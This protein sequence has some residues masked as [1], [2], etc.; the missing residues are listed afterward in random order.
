MVIAAEKQRLMLLLTTV[1][2]LLQWQLGWLIAPLWLLW[3]LLLY[4]HRD[5]RRHIP[6][7]PLAVI[8]PLDGRVTSI[9]IAT[10]P[11]LKRTALCITIRQ[12]LTGEFNLHSPTE[13]RIKRRW[14]PGRMDSENPAENAYAWWVQTDE[15]DDVVVELKAPSGWLRSVSSEIQTGERIG[16]GKRLGF[17]GYLLTARV[18]V[19]DNAESLTMPGEVLLAGQ[20]SVARLSHQHAEQSGP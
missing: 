17:G 15:Q 3:A 12:N 13:G 20:A 7:V 5:L 9:D 19:P 8:S 11:Y 1:L 18:F 2:V 16:Q 4:L 6:A 10:D 14:W